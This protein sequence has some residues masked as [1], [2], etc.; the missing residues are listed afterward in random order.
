V[1]MCATIKLRSK[2]LGEGVFGGLVCRRVLKFIK[3]LV[4]KICAT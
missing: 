2:F 3:R 4:E 1:K